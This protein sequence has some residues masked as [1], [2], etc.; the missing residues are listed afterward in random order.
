M[1]K[2]DIKGISQWSPQEEPQARCEKCRE[3][4]PISEFFG[5]Q[6]DQICSMCEKNE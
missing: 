6:E 4:F 2:K 5:D 1:E 3:W